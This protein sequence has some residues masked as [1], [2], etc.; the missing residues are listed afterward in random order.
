M[1]WKVWLG[2]VLCLVIVRFTVLFHVKGDN[3][4]FVVFSCYAI[5]TWLTVMV[6]NMVE[7]HRLMNYLKHN[8]RAKWEELTYVPFF[9]P[10]GMNGLR[11]LPFLYSSDDLNDPVVGELK[12]N[13]RRFLKLT[14]IVFFTLP[15]L[16]ITVMLPWGS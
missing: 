8:H 9:G 5:P 2:L 3:A 7:G 12:L 4:L 6:L 14:L 10:G 1:Y 15:V 13:Y 11:T 16:F